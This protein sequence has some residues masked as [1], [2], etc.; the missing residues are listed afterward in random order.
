MSRAPLSIQPKL[1]IGAVDDPLEREAD[2]VAE[3]VMRI[4]D[5]AA[6]GKGPVVQRKCSCGGSC[7]KCQGQDHDQLQMKRASSGDIGHTSAPPIVHEVLGSSGHSLDHVT[8]KSMEARFHFDFSRVRI[9]DDARAAQV[10]SSCGS[11]RAYTVG[12]DLAF[13]PG[14]YLRPGPRRATAACWRT[15]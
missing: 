6:S 1:E 7:D 12:R 10:G 2:A 14:Q 8:Q 15:N 3:R 5:P 13:G 11:A 4:P 9:H